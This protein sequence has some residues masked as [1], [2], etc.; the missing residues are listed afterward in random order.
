MKLTLD[1]DEKN[2]ESVKR[3]AKHLNRSESTVLDDLIAT[4]CNMPAIATSDLEEF[5]IKQL[6]K[7][8]NEDKHRKSSFT[9]ERIKTYQ[10]VL[11]FVDSAYKAQK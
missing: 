5:C 11:F 9:E 8:D 10:R 7:C 2:V 1:L 4:F 3:I 6:E